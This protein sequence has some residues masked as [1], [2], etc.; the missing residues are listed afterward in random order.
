MRKIYEAMRE[1]HGFRILDYKVDNES[2]APRVCFNFSEQLARK[3]D[4]APYVAVSGASNTAISTED[5]QICVEGLKHGERYAIVLRQ[6]LPSAVGESLLKSADYEIYVRDRSPQAHFA[7][8]AYVLP[9]QGQE[10]APLVTVNTAKVAIDVYRIGDRN[11]L[12]TVSRDDFL[13]PI[14]T[15][16]AQDIE[17]TDGVKVWSGSMDV[18]SELNKDVVTEFPGPQGGRAARSQASISSPRVR[19]RRRRPN[20]DQPEYVQ[21]ATQWMVVSDLGLTAMSG[22]DGVHALVESLGSAGPLAGVELK[23]VARN[24]EVLATKTTGPDGRV[25]F[26]PGLS[27]GK[28]GSAPGLLVATLA[29]DYN[30]LNLAQNAFDLTDRGVDGRDAPAGLDAFLY[31]ERGVYRSGETVFATALLRDAKG[32]ATPRPA[33]DARRQAAGRRRV[34]ARDRWPTRAWADAPSR[35]R[36]CR[37]RPRESGRSRPTP[38]RRATRSA[39][40]SSC[41]RT[42]FPSGSTSPCIPPKPFIDPGE[43]VE[44]TLDARFLYGAPASGLDVTGAIRLQA[45]ED[46]ALAGFPGYVAGLADD[47]FTA[48]QNQFTRQ[49]ADRRQGPRRPVGRPARRDRDAA[50][51]GEAHR[52]RR[53]ARRAHGRAHRDAAGAGEGRHG[54]GEEGLRQ[55][56]RRR[57]TRRPSR[58]SPSRPTGRASRARARNGRS[59]R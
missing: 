13:K 53:R 18:A 11:L 40:S 54:R 6:G 57:A 10:G 36:S 52:R 48:V 43:P 56:D 32:V 47:E 59:I 51:R 49:G 28:G 14:D 34:Q 58:R 19:G 37:A 30:F 39:K 8:K 24:N 33:A 20:S 41:S 2:S 29:D 45:V 4:F 9:R 16:R 42:I 21:L 55:F 23:L 12:A 46:A 38:T 35:F 50:A 17:N 27:R 3:T 15:S 22:D 31:T 5:Q 44:L 26:D 1:E 7:G 25:D